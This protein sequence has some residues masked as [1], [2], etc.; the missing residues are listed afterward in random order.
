MMSTSERLTLAADRRGWLLADQL[1]ERLVEA[2]LA[3][4]DAGRL[5]DAGAL[6]I[7]ALAHAERFAGDDPR[8][9]TAL[10]N[11][12]AV[13]HLRGGAA[14][15][16]HF[17][18]AALDAWAAAEPWIETMA[19]APRARSSPCHPRL[20]A[21]HRADDHRIARAAPRK[22]LDEGRATC[23]ANL[24][25]LCRSAGRGADA[26]ALEAEASER[27]PRGVKPGLARWTVLAPPGPCD[28]RKLAAAVLLLARPAAPT[29]EAAR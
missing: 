12:A 15:A 27:A 14:D 7:S 23:L 24:A 21:K 5:D 22:L 13:R 6:W 11:I 28:E 1:W 8:R 19:A 29:D 9:A 3:A 16:E 25:A 2:G 18:R 10:N 17:Y 20:E 4:F 26:D